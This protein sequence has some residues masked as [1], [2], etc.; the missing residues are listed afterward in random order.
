MPV[1]R[2]GA[3]RGKGGAAK[4]RAS[5]AE[6]VEAIATRTRR[7]RAAAAAG[8]AVPKIANRIDDNDKEQQPAVNKNV[9]PAAAVAEEVAVPEKQG[10]LE[11]EKEEVG[12]KPMDDKSNDKEDENG[13]APLPEKVC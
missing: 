13:T 9:A 5:P 3:G 10:D 11:A 1:P 8:V 4:R 7:R 12:E 2:S 6:P